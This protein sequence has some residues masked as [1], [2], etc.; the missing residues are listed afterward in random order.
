MVVTLT[1]LTSASKTFSLSVVEGMGAGV[2]FS[3]PSGA[4]TLGDGESRTVTVSMS[5]ARGAGTGHK[6]AVLQVSAGGQVVA[7]RCCMPW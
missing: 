7:T 6:Q 1:N 3:V 4:V 5:A 2:T